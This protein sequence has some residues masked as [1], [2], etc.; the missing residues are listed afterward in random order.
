MR[1][2]TIIK[3]SAG[4]SSLEWM[5]KKSFFVVAKNWFVFKVAS[6]FPV[7]INNF[8][9]SLSGMK[10]GKN[11]QI[12][13]HQKFDIFFPELIEIGEG[14]VVGFN[15]VISCHEFNPNE[16]KIGGVEI[17][18]NVLIGARSIILPGISIG[19]EAIVGAQ[20]T[21][22]KDIPKKGKAYSKTIIV[23]K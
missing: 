9:F 7:G 5:K 18:K 4:K 23:S 8:F 14:S 15:C 1:N 10:I 19:D 16:L 6:I 22:S 12:M 20:A 3:C 17:G 13:P 21:I 2:L 11:V